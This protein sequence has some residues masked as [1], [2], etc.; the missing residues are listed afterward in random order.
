M[1]VLE[2]HENLK[3]FKTTYIAYLYAYSTFCGTEK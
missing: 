2:V 3:M 1:T